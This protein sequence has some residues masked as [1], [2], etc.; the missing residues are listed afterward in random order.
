M[1]RVAPIDVEVHDTCLTIVVPRDTWLSST[2]VFTVARTKRASLSPT[3]SLSGKL[4]LNVVI[5]RL[6]TL[7]VE[8]FA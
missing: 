3:P 6:S 4:M 8:T 7:I 5:T 1:S 2:N